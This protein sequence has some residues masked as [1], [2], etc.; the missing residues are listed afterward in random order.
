MHT[1]FNQISNRNVKVY[2]TGKILV[3]PDAAEVHM[4]VVTQNLEATIAQQENARIVQ[5]V[6]Q[7]LEEL[8]IPK[9]NIQTTDYSIFPQYDYVNNLQQFKGYQVTNMLAVTVS[10]NLIGEVI[11]TAIANG[12]NR[13]TDITF[14]VTNQEAYY[15][16]ALQLALY[17]AYNKAETISQTLRASLDPT[18]VTTLEQPTMQP[19]T[20]YKLVSGTEMVGGIATPIEPGRIEI[21]ARIEI[22]YNI[23]T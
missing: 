15:Q 3:E 21:E 5:Q 19:P 17:N 18:P 6:I 12:I 23:F 10:I 11:D 16:R 1:Q 13:M 9:E 14:A 20:P 22:C 2:G 7:S 4:G 8:G